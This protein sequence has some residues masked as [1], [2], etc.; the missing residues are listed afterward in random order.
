MCVCARAHARARA[1]V[2]LLLSIESTEHCKLAM[3]EKLGIIKKNVKREFPWGF[4]EI[5]L[6]RIHEDAV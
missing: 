2:T 4:S 6:T 1:W 5:N 3:M